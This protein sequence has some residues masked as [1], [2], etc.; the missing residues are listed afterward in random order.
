MLDPDPFPRSWLRVPPRGFN[1]HFFVDAKHNTVEDQF[2]KKTLA[3]AHIVLSKTLHIRDEYICGVDLV[4][5]INQFFT[6]SGPLSQW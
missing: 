3:G 5:G 1:D 2:Y 4:I 6:V